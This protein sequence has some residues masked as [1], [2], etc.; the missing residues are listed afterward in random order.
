MILGLLVVLLFRVLFDLFSN[1]W[2]ISELW[3]NIQKDFWVVLHAGVRGAGLRRSLDSEWWAWIIERFSSPAFDPV[4]TRGNPSGFCTAS[5]LHGELGWKDKVP[6]FSDLR[7]AV[8]HF[9]WAL[10]ESQRGQ[11]MIDLFILSSSLLWPCLLVSCLSGIEISQV[12]HR[13]LQC[14]WQIF[15]QMAALWPHGCFV[16]SGQQVRGYF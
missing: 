2:T 7:S 11:K 1:K 13:S 3:W 4:D 12:L 15:P 5:F 10:L 6:F 9:H 16:H 8:D 14:F